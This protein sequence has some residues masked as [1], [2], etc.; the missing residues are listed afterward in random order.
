MWPPSSPWAWLARTTMASAF[1]RLMEAM[2]S[3]SDRLPGKGGSW[4]AA[5][6]LR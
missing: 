1:Q 6:V 5:M 3:S 4:S 2:R